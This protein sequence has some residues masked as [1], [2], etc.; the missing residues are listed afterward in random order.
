MG[1]WVKC[2]D[3]LPELDDMVWL[4]FGDDSMVIGERSSSTD[5]WMWSACYAP[6]FDNGKWEY[7]DGEPL[8]EDPTHWMSLPEPPK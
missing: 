2:E 3:S 4:R 8:D 6:Y 5:G 1:N 7:V